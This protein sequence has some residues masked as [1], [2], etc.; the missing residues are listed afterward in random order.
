MLAGLPPPANA[1]LP[2]TVLGGVMRQT[3]GAQHV[4]ATYL[5]TDS[6]R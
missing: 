4:S 5:A 6:Q 1:Q 3:A 2:T